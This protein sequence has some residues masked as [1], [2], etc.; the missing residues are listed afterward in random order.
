MLKTLFLDL[1]IYEYCC[2]WF[3]QQSSFNC[4]HETL[5]T[6]KRCTHLGTPVWN[7]SP[8]LSNICHC[9][10]CNKHA[11][12][13]ASSTLL[14]GLSF[15]EEIA[16]C[17]QLNP[18]YLQYNAFP[19][20]N[21]TSSS[22]LNIIWPYFGTHMHLVPYPHYLTGYRMMYLRNNGTQQRPFR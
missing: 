18:K 21:C 16:L 17:P 19:V 8:Y 20:Y 3:L 12:C 11:Q 5:V 1:K 13:N 6:N 4:Y 2:T 14:H 22:A 7:G 10:L 9:L 15:I